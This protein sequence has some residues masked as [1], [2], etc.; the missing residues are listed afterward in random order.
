ME[1]WSPQFSYSKLVLS[2]W[3][4]AVT[5]TFPFTIIL[6][7]FPPCLSPMLDFLFW[8]ILHL[9]FSW[10]MPHFGRAEPSRVAWE[11]WMIEGLNFMKMW[12]FFD[13][14]PGCR[15][16]KQNFSAQLRRHFSIVF[17]LQWCCWE[18][19]CYCSPYSFVNFIYFFTL[20]KFL[21]SSLYPG[22]HHVSDKSCERICICFYQI[23]G[24]YNQS[25]I[26]VHYI[27][28]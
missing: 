8:G 15:F 22:V 21:G 19:S 26:N 7:F 12:H 5:G 20:W 27:F 18:I 10:C 2:A 3:H 23:L 6:R 1:I 25:G 9:S 24:R 13:C 11:R 4:T 14:F 16:L 17:R 28:G